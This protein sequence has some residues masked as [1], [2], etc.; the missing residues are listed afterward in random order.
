MSHANHRGV[1]HKLG[2][3]RSKKLPVFAERVLLALNSG[4]HGS[5]SQ[6]AVAFDAIMTKCIEAYAI[7]LKEQPGR[8]RPLPL[9]TE[10]GNPANAFNERS[11]ESLSTVDNTAHH[12]EL[13][14]N[15][16]EMLKR[17]TRYTANCVESNLSGMLCVIDTWDHREW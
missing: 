4:V 5:I 2:F 16:A 10:T 3:G 15:P 8:R 6:F 13:T 1:N 14:A 12:A 7:A 17:L 9:Q 11:A